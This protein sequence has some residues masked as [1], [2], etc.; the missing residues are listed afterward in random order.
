LCDVD[1]RLARGNR[2]REPTLRRAL[3]S[4]SGLARLESRWP[5]FAG[6]EMGSPRQPDASV[7]IVE[8]VSGACLCL[9]REMFERLHGFDEAY[10]LHCED[11]DLCRR[12]RDSGSRVAI[13]NSLRA[14]HLQGASSRARPIFVERHKHRGMWRYFRKYD[15]AAR[16]PL[17]RAIVWCGIWTHFALTASAMALKRMGARPA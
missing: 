15:P 5:V 17:L 9:R 2:R 13:A 11:L 8:A 4:I 1:G 3:I 7:E 14:R 10:F 16:N 6:V 12:V